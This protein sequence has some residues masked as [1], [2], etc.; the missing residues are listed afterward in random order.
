MKELHKWVSTI[1]A[2]GA[3][4]YVALAYYVTSE[5]R[6]NAL[7]LQGQIDVLKQQ[8]IVNVK[9]QD[10]VVE[11]DKK[12]AKLEVTANQGYQ[13]VVEVRKL[14]E[15]VSQLKVEIAKR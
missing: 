1:I 10:L 9:V 7:V 15:E 2:V 4:V 11:I 6:N 3:V 12:L 8:Q 5:D 13:L 14:R